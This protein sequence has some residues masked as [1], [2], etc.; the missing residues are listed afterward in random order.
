MQ[1]FKLVESLIEPSGEVSL[2]AGDLLQGLIYLLLGGRDVKVTLFA[3]P[4]ENG[5][6]LIIGGD[7]SRGR[8]LLR[9]WGDSLT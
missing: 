6:R 3:I 4:E 9:M 2:V 7:S 8:N 5:T 1:G